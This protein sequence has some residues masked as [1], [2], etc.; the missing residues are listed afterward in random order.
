LGLAWELVTAKGRGMEWEAMGTE[1][2]KEQW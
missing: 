1:T 2:A